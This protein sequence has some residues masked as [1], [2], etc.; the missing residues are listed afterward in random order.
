MKGKDNPAWKPLNTSECRSKE[1][2]KEM[3]T[4][5]NPEEPLHKKVSQVKPTV[6]LVMQ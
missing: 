5:A 6:V 1:Y 3:M 2:Y 4:S